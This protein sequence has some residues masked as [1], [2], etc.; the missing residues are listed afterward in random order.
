[1]NRH[2]TSEQVSEFVAGAASQSMRE[3]VAG[4]NDCHS[5]V[6]RLNDSLAIFRQS[7]R[8][9]SLEQEQAPF[10]LEIDARASRRRI[11][12]QRLG[13]TAILTACLI[14]GLTLPH[15]RNIEPMSAQRTISD[16]D[17][18]VQVD[19]ELAEAV[20]PSLAPIALNATTGGSQNEGQKR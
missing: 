20:P 10:T 14:T 2:L 18:L 15:H 7:V 17:L 11:T 6:E 8:Q 16:A 1:M 5:E 9:W 3:H 13:W 4:C 12:L 19:K